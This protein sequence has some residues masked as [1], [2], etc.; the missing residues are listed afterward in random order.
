MPRIRS[1]HPGQWSDDQFVELS[2]GAR[3]LAIAIRNFADDAGRFEWNE[4]KLKMWCFP[5]DNRNM[6]P[7]LKELR[8]RSMIRRYSVAGKAYGEIR[9]FTRFQRIRRPSFQYPE[10]PGDDD[11]GNDGD[12]SPPDS[13]NHAGQTEHDDSGNRTAQT[14][15]DSGNDPPTRPPD[16]RNATAYSPPDSRNLDSEV[17]GRRLD[18]ESSANTET[19][20]LQQSLGQTGDCAR[21]N[22][23]HGGG[24]ALPAGG[25]SSP[26]SATRT[27]QRVREITPNLAITE[28]L[29]ARANHTQ[30]SPPDD[31]ER[32]QVVGGTA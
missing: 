23:A 11:S 32:N 1:T 15:S 18:S 29:A 13:R 16:S 20:L 4:K 24:L 6:A 31:D 9:N 5:A 10:P 28:K 3:L 26:P 27:T 2:D 12:N 17:G 14:N 8:E 21:E 7:L 25:P 19:N 22:S 30:R